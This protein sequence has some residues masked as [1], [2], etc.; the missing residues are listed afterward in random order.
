MPSRVACFARPQES[1]EVPRFGIPVKNAQDVALVNGQQ[2]PARSRKR[3]SAETIGTMNPMHTA[4]RCGARTRSGGTCCAP[5]VRGKRRCRIHGGKST[6][7]RTPEGQERSRRAR[8][9]H[10]RYYRE[11]QE[12]ARETRWNDPGYVEAPRLAAM[13]RF[14]REDARAARKQTAE[15]RALMRRL[16]LE[17]CL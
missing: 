5:V 16:E 6:G 13:R 12:A 9:K 2:N 7:P 4:P 1:F 11:D 10:G 17:A 8:W 14:A 15:W 3:I